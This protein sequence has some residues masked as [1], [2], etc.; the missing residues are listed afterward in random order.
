V[1]AAPGRGISLI[2]G[3]LPAQYGFQTAGV[4]DIQV[5]VLN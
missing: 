3:V 1:D 4:L 5:T 2:T